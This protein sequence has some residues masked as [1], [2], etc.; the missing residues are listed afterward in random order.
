[1]PTCPSCDAAVK[2]TFE[3]LVKPLSCRACASNNLHPTRTSIAVL[4]TGGFLYLPLAALIFVEV[5]GVDPVALIQ[6]RNSSHD[7]T[8]GT[9]FYMVG[10]FAWLM[11]WWRIWRQKYAKLYES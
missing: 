10:A 5:F 2:L 6:G 9:L 7:A 3:R 8:A 1:M 4:I 11:L